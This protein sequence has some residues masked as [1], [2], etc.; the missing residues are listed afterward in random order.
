V[1]QK[2]E[3]RASAT[4]IA[5]DEIDSLL[6][7]GVGPEWIAWRILAVVDQ[8]LDRGGGNMAPGV[9]GGIVNKQFSIVAVDPAIGKGD[10]KYT[11]DILYAA[12]CQ[13][14]STRFKNHLPRVVQGGDKCIQNIP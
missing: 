7:T 3:Q 2:E 9:G 6:H 8:L 12:R 11:A 1:N 13:K 5:T 10:V 14:V 4:Q